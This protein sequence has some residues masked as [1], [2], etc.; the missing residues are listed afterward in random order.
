[1]RAGPHLEE[2]GP[3]EINDGSAASPVHTNNE[4]FSDS[5]NQPDAEEPSS[6]LM[7]EVDGNDGRPS[8]VPSS[9]V[10]VASEA[11]AAAPRESIERDEMAEHAADSTPIKPPRQLDPL[12]PPLSNS[13]PDPPNASLTDESSPVKVM[14][15]AHPPRPP[16][17]Y[18]TFFTCDS[19]P[20]LSST[21]LDSL[22]HPLSCRTQTVPS[23]PG[24]SGR[25]CAGGR[26]GARRAEPARISH[27]SGERRSPGGGHRRRPAPQR[28]GA[29]RRRRNGRRGSR[30][31]R[32]AHP[33]RPRRR[34]ARCKTC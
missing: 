28:L 25:G 34:R 12:Q 2:N 30:A 10:V 9:T 3:N 16:Y 14:G 33:P 32:S 27:G 7:T 15:I 4:T 29:G 13:S 1:M 22:P 21:P 31:D 19:E 6:Q 24:R 18:L 20:A 17:P 26:W 8:P 11:A 23:E 5:K